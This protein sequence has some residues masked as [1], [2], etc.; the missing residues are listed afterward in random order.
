MAPQS[1]G[2]QEFKKTNHQMLQRPIPKHQKNCLYVVLLLLQFKDN[3]QNFRWHSYN[4]LNHLKWIRIKKILRF[5]SRRGP[6]RRKKKHVLK[7]GKLISRVIFHYSFSFTLHRWFLELE[8]VLSYHFKSLKK[9]HIWW[10]Y[11]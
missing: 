9:K 10:R 5:E 1:R 8:V 3:L 11:K 4:T 7:V 6:K 2:G